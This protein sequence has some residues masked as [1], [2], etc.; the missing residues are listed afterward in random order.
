MVRNEQH[1]IEIVYENVDTVL[2]G[3]GNIFTVFLNDGTTA[4]FHHVDEDGSEWEYFY[5]KLY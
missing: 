5:L 4:T 3:I 1:E 2:T